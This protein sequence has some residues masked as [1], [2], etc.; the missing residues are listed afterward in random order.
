MTSMLP[1]NL[2]AAVLIIPGEEAFILASSSQAN[3]TSW[4]YG[5][6]SCRTINFV[7]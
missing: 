1:K 2:N 3:L 7:I 6:Y 5:G 4:A